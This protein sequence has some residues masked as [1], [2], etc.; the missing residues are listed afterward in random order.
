MTL[1]YNAAVY[2]LRK[3]TVDFAFVTANLVVV[4]I[5]R[6][7]VIVNL[8]DV[9]VNRVNVTGNLVN[10]IDDLDDVTGNLV[11]VTDDLDNVIVGCVDAIVGCV[12]AITNF[13]SVI[14]RHGDAI[15]I[16][17]GTA[18]KKSSCIYKI[19]CF[20]IG[21]IAKPVRINHFTSDHGMDF[22]GRRV[23]FYGF[24]SANAVGF[25]VY[26]IQIPIVGGV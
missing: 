19:N 1:I 15:V 18:S 7:N 21:G 10:R 16:D 25:L 5:N 20:I 26:F 22:D 23:I 14:C 17:V 12:D 4:T 3:K 9:I 2:I 24:C 6:V 8:D 11:V 13:K